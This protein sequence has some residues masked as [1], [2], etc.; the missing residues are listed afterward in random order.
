MN[1]INNYCISGDSTDSLFM[2]SST[3]VVSVVG[4]L[5]REA[6]DFYMINIAVSLTSV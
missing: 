5:D 6:L 3:G 4:V 2:V 1:M